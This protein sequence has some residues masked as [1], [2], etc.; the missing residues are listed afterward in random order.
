MEPDRTDRD[1][2]RIQVVDYV[3]KS[4]TLPDSNL[5]DASPIVISGVKLKPKKISI[6]MFD[7]YAASNV[8]ARSCSALFALTRHPIDTI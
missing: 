4:P 5:Q 6:L 7:F 3:Y 1:R 8:L 2:P